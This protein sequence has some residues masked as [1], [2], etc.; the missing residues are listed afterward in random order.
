S[1][2]PAGARLFYATTNNLPAP[3]NTPLTLG[4]TTY[5]F[6][7]AFV[8]TGLPTVLSLSLRHVVDDGVVIYL[9]GAEIHRFNVPQGVITFTNNASSSVPNAILRSPINVALTNLVL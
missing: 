7:T 3:K 6:R 1:G 4:T 2:W 5:Y 9:N 8:F